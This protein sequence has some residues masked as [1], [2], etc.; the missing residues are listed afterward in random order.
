LSEIKVR[1]HAELAPGPS[2]EERI[3]KGGDP[4]K[5]GYVCLWR[6]SRKS[7]IFA[8]DGMWKLFCL[9]LMSAA[10]EPKEIMV[11]AALEPVHLEPGQL[12]CGRQAL[13]EQYHQ[14]DMWPG[15][16]KKKLT[17]SPTTLYRW[18]LT[19]Q[20]MQT[21]HIEPFNKYSIITIANWPRYQFAGQQANN[22]RTTGE[23][24][25]KRTATCI[26]K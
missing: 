26:F 13:W 5:T 17:P 7:P 25:E 15:R 21:L 8:R 12:L 22:R 19:M 6:R 11:D 10:W 20:K 9:C 1:R 4:M 23:H 14:I 16:P 3:G 18:L 2:L 24:K